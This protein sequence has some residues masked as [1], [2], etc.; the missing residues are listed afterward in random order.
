MLG[1]KNGFAN[2][3]KG[4][5]PEISYRIDKDESVLVKARIID[6]SS[7]EIVYETQE[8]SRSND[9]YKFTWE[10]ADQ[11]RHGVYLVEILMEKDG[12]F[13]VIS[14]ERIVIVK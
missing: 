13:K 2:V 9:E 10:A 4:E 14:R 5:M 1:L 8:E 12:E 11:V 6:L 7:S 3:S